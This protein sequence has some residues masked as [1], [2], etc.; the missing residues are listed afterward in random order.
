[1]KIAV[2]SGK[3]GT[4]KTFVSTS[5]AVTFTDMG[6][7]VTYVDCDVEKPNKLL[8][9][10]PDITS[11][12]PFTVQGRIEGR[13]KHGNLWSIDVHS[14]TTDSDD[15]QVASQLINKMK[16]MAGKGI[17]IFDS[18]SGMGFPLEETLKDIDYCV[19]VIPP[20]D[21]TLLWLPHVIETCRSA[22]YRPGIVTNRNTFDSVSF[23]EMLE[24]QDLPILGGIP[25]YDPRIEEIC[26]EGNVVL[27][28]LPEYRDTFRRIAENILIEF[29][30]NGN[31]HRQVAKAS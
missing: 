24:L 23:L 16:T 22:G 25:Y 7:K 8:A 9:F 30:L 3:E 26:S 17:T 1:M 21:K 15:P 27:D 10:H 12:D 28:I 14:G 31:S 13:I 20:V 18:P 5:L 29:D 2:S 11:V 4:G 19:L 6:R